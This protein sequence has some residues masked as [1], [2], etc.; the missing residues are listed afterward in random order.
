MAVIGVVVAVGAAYGQ[1]QAGQSQKAMTKYNADLAEN[2]A[3]AQEQATAAETERMRS[4]KKRQMSAQ[5]AAASK[6]GA[7]ISEGTPLLVMAEEA[8]LMELDIMNM[9][10]TGAM[11]AQASRSEA[12]LQKYKGKQAARSANIQA[13]TTLL[14]GLGKGA[15]IHKSNHTDAATGKWY[16]GKNVGKG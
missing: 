9:Q 3:I 2:E 5:R 8:G 7:V 1:Y 16:I 13:G 12:K 4:Q 15:A 10:R 14:G 6:T 11:Q